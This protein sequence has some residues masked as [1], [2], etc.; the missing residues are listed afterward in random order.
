MPY[1]MYFWK[2]SDIPETSFCYDILFRHIR[3]VPVSFISSKNFVPSILVFFS[4]FM[5][6]FIVLSISIF[7]PYV[8]YVKSTE[9]RDSYSPVIHILLCCYLA[10]VTVLIVIRFREY[11]KYH[12]FLD[13]RKFRDGKA[14]LL[15]AEQIDRRVYFPV[16]WTSSFLD[17]V[18]VVRFPR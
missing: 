10:V 13:Q 4:I 5:I 14:Q 8:P 3:V 7:H 18:V 12:A 17:S 6:L 16:S 2:S 11:I 9:V 1:L 15:T